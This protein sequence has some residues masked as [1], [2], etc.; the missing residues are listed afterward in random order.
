[1]PDSTPPPTRRRRRADAERSI[2]AILDAAVDELGERPGASMED[3]A[4]AAGVARQTIYAHFASREA[5]LDAV[6]QR[7][8]EQAVADIDATRPDEGPP[9]AALD[10]LVA[11]SWQ[12]LERHSRLLD[13]F[14][15]ALG[16]EQVHALHRPIRDRLDP[17]IRRGQREGVFDRGLS[18]AWAFAAVIGVFHA[19]AQE[20]GAGRM[21]AE[22]AARA[23]K[24]AVPRLL[25][26]TD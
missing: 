3:I 26:A 9:A 18:P 25:G 22:D 19:T 24:R 2:A 4:G 1:M 11:A 15:A 17:L 13:S 16:P 10:R 20:V 8:L 12:T 5:L 23:L 7:A 6:Q 14:F 21:S